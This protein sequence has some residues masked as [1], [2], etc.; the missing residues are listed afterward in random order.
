[1]AKSHPCN[2]TN[3]NAFHAWAIVSTADANVQLPEE[4]TLAM[5]GM[6]KPNSDQIKLLTDPMV[7]LAG[8]LGM[9][10]RGLSKRSTV[11]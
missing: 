5:I 2:P 9:W 1:M 11:L 6:E 4:E 10:S 8:V 7:I 3:I